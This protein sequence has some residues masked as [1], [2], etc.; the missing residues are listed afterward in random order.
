MTLACAAMT[1]QA[2]DHTSDELAP[3][4]K[5]RFEKN[6]LYVPSS[7]ASDSSKLLSAK[8]SVSPYSATLS[9]PF[10]KDKVNFDLG[11]DFRFYDKRN[12]AEQNRYDGADYNF[13][14]DNLLSP[15]IYASAMFKLPVSGLTASI[16]GRHNGETSVDKSYV[17]YQ[18]R[19]SYKWKNGLGLEGG[20]QHQQV[21]LDPT[22]EDSDVFKVESLFL[23]MKY[24]F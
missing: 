7:L 16:S 13:D 4:V 15:K 14:V 20:W 8:N 18:A 22:N 1:V 10:N 23:D 21:S 19:L 5:F 12:E 6:P 11:L 9:V 2:Q 24:K 3:A 17:D